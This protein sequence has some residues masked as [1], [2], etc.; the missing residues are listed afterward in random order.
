MPLQLI[1]QLL[2]NKLTAADAHMRQC[3]CTVDRSHAAV[4]AFLLYK[5]FCGGRA[6]FAVHMYAA[7]KR[8]RASARGNKSN[9]LGKPTKGYKMRKPRNPTD[10]SMHHCRHAAKKAR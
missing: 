3:K 10:L 2:A 6:R 8:G 5:D 7:D 9:P 1:S 4:Y